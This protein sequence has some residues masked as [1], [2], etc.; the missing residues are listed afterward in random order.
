MR[1]YLT[2]LLL[3]LGMIPGILQAQD[4]KWLKDITES[5]GLRRVKSGQISACDL[6]GDKYP[7]LLLQNL[8]YNRSRQTRLYLNI[9]NP[10]SASPNARKFI[11]ITDSS[12]IYFNRNSDTMGRVADV[13]GMA[14]L[15]NDGYPD[16]ITGLFYFNVSTFQ[17]VGDRAEVFL[18]DG[19]GRFTLVQ[20]SGLPELGQFPTTGFSFLDYDMDGKL[21][22]YI[23]TFSADHQNN[24]WIPGI[25]LKGNGDGT[26]TDMSSKSGIDQVSEPLYGCSV[27][28]WNNDGWPDILTSPYCRTE[29][30]LWKNKGDGTFENVSTQ[31]G[32]TS[33]N[34]MYG[35]IDA[36]GQLNNLLLFPRELCQWEA[37]PWDYDNDGD[38]DI[39]Q[40]L[41]HG[42]LDKGEGRTTLTR[43]EGP[44][45]N[46]KLTWQLDKF[47][48][49]LINSTSVT[50]VKIVNDTSWTNQYGSFELPAGTEINVSNYGHLGDQAGSWLDIDN[51]MLS[52]FLLSTTGYDAVNDRCYIQH[53][54]PDHSFKEIARQLG[55]RSIL[56]ETHSSRPMDIDLDGDDDFIIE[57]APRTANAE[58]GRVWVYRNDIGNANNHCTISLKAPAGCNTNAI[59]AR[60]KVY[61]A[62]ICQTRD[63]QSGTGRWGMTSPWI[64][65]F[66][67]GTTQKIDSITVTWPMKGFP[68][69]TVI[70]PPANTM[71]TIGA[72][73][74]ST[75]IAENTQENESLRVWPQPSAGRLTAYIPQEFQNGIM[76]IYNSGGMLLQEQNLTGEPAVRVPSDQLATGYYMLRIMSGRSILSTSFIISR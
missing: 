69:T 28:D 52:D 5:T 75:G 4:T 6:N 41:I 1:I 59:G 65:N 20:N 60:V 45:Q 46:Y 48:R 27:T 11:D 56:K 8:S 76:Q 74:I 62:G 26:F 18:N 58:S 50:K 71:L 66:G 31:A 37:L 64:L 68:T 40:M 35:N 3:F 23:G 33:K 44:A 39:A 22:V 17:D 15:N 47:D 36:G 57:Y 24:V 21:D 29:G 51:D 42:G 13:W 73:G 67:L 54:Q 9:Q 16:I 43:N 25:L 53:Q 12:R 61:A 49:P 34:G 19:T 32:Y 72:G 2:G 30:T 10:D 14:D 7:D 70:N 55:V 38:M 63:I